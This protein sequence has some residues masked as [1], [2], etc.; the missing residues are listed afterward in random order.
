MPAT[1]AAG[2]AI[3]I[4]QLWGTVMACGFAAGVVGITITFP[5]LITE[6]SKQDMAISV[7]RLTLIAVLPFFG[8]WGILASVALA[9]ASAFTQDI[10][11][12]N[13]RAKIKEANG[14]AEEIKKDRE[15]L[16]IARKEMLEECAAK[17]ESAR[18]FWQNAKP[19]EDVHAALARYKALVE[20]NKAF[21][22]KVIA[23]L[24]KAGESAEAKNLIA[25]LEELK[26]TVEGLVANDH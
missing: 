5:F 16:I 20:Q 6:I 17:N 21:F 25:T 3:V 18:E 4:N 8:T 12:Y 24:D 23:D 22:D 2:V 9:A 14:L 26:K 19:L 15:A 7:A 11:L 10:R 13:I 1:I